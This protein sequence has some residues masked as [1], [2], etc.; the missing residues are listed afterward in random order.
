ML[1]RRVVSHRVDFP[2]LSFQTHLAFM[3]SY[4]IDANAKSEKRGSSPGWPVRFGQDNVLCQG[5]QTVGYKRASMLTRKPFWQLRYG[6]VK[7]CYPSL[8]ENE[9]TFT[10]AEHQTRQPLHVVD[11]PGHPQLRFIVSQY[12]PIAR[13]VLFFVDSSNFSKTVRD[14]AEALYDVL[15]DPKMAPRLAI[16]CNKQDLW[17]SW[18]QERIKEELEKE[19]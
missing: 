9:G 1:T 10:P 5:G 13:S 17:G 12:L 3:I 6:T 4:C 15:V 7:A 14:T 16:V 11:L 18:V 8:K 19:M 2:R